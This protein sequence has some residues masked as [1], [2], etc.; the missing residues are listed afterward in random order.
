MELEARLMS[1]E[2]SSVNIDRKGDTNQNILAEIIDKV[3]SKV[4]SL[5]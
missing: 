4:L 1:S 2:Q 5:E 3:E